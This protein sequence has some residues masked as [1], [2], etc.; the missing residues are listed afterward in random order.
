MI[1][2]AK[3]GSSTA[4][5][6]ERLRSS[7][8]STNSTGASPRRGDRLYDEEL[9]GEEELLQDTP[10]ATPDARRHRRKSMRPGGVRTD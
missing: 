6:F 5:S 8:D 4:S 3:D 10:A 1:S 9:G 2:S 7:S